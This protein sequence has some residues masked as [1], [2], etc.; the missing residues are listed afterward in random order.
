MGKKILIESILAVSLILMM[1]SIPAIEQKTIEDGAYHDFTE[2]INILDDD[3]KLPRLYT[4]LRVILVLRWLRG[5]IYY[6]MAIDW[7]SFNV[8]KVKYSLIYY[9]AAWLIETTYSIAEKID[10]LSDR[11][12]LGWGDILF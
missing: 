12:G 2:E 9:R 6:Y 1:P 4:L 11:L 5:R 10:I 8:Y 3:I 7:I